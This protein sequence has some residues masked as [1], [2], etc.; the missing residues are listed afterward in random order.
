MIP[1]NLLWTLRGL[2]KKNPCKQGTA[3]ERVKCEDSKIDCVT[4]T[5][6]SRSVKPYGEGDEERGLVHL[7][8]EATCF[9][10]H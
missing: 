7:D 10:P 3:K 4:A 8:P 5:G 9:I 2:G 1:K 6:R